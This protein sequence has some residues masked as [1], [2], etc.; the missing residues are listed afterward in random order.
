MSPLRKHPVLAA[1]SALSLIAFFVSTY[2]LFGFVRDYFRAH[3]PSLY[4]VYLIPD[5]SFIHGERQ[6]EVI[7]QP[8][9]RQGPSVLVKYGDQSLR[10][11]VAIPPRVD[12]PGLVEHQSWMRVLLWRSGEGF[13]ADAMRELKERG[14]AEGELVIVT[15]SQRPGADPETFG[16]VFKSDWVFDFYEL[17]REPDA[18]GSLIRHSR[19][20][21]PEGKRAFERRRQAAIAKGLPPPERHADELHEGTWQYHAA[22]SVMPTGKAPA[23]AFTH[24]GL[25]ASG[26][27][28]TCAALSMVAFI[29]STALLFAP[30]RVKEAPQPA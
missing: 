14:A 13:D 26:W 7:D 20:T 18:S 27:R 4:Y 16:E 17:L 8:D 5:E 10:L 9:D 1:C 21:Y 11:P 30:D 12:L 2:L 24:Q 19:L 3:P 28:W 15:R 22:M 25:L 23:R 6:V 29:I